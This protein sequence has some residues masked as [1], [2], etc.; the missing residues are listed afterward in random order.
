MF[1]IPGQSPV[2][3]TSAAESQI[4]LRND[5]L[6]DIVVGRAGAGSLVPASWGTSSLCSPLTTTSRDCPPES[7]VRWSPACKVPAA[8]VLK[9]LFL[10]AYLRGA[11][12]AV[13]DTLTD[14]ILAFP[15]LLLLL[16]LAVHHQ[17]GKGGLILAHFKSHHGS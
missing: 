17:K 10:A 16:A 5:L 12:E 1:G 3:L 13:V 4:R 8:S 6:L 9:V 2:K 11:F 14:S 15:P 7:R